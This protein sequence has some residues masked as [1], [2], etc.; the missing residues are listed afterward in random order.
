MRQ[1][2]L[3]HMTET[4][5]SEFESIICIVHLLLFLAVGQPLWRYFVESNHIFWLHS[6]YNVRY[7]T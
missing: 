6:F 4:S 1:K 7:K 5:K 2:D 3:L